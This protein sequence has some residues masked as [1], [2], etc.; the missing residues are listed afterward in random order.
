VR[1][2]GLLE[3]VD[4]DLFADLFE[5]AFDELD[6]EGVDLIIVLSFLV[7][8]E[9]VEGDLI[10]LIHDRSMAG[11]HFAYVKTEDA[12]NGFEEFICASDEFIGGFGVIGVGPEN[13]NV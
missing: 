11:D 4:D 2:S 3:I 9:Q 10:R 5:N 13:D 12:G 1:Q 8:E 7:G 6:M